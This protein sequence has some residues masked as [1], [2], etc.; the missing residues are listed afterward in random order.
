MSIVL[1]HRLRGYH[2]LLEMALKQERSRP[3]PDDQTLTEIRKKKLKIK[4][5]LAGLDRPAHAQP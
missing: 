5:R 3:G 1:V 4:D 2:S